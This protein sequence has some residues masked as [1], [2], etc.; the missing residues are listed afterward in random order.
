MSKITISIDGHSSCGKSTLAKDLAKELHYAYVDSGAMY[1]AVTL[2]FLENDVDPIDAPIV[3]NALENIEIRFQ[4]LDGQNHTFLNGEDVEDEIREMYVSDYVSPVAAIPAVRRSL[5]RQQREMG[6]AGGIVMDG[7]D[8][9]T[10][11]FPGAEL[12]IFLTADVDIRTRR[13]YDELRAKGVDIDLALVKQNLLERDHIDSNRADSPLT[14]AK[15]AVVID[16]SYL[17]RTQQ[18][19]QAL[20]LAKERIR[21]S[22]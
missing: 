11:V 20:K 12:K 4:V 14:K 16:N 7:R 6:K 8:I 9:G 19:Q 21:L 15:D 13:R 17:N 2:F 1:R 22:E 10:V 5:V 3:R 18:L